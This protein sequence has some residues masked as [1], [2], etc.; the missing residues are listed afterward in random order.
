MLAVR[1]QLAIGLLLLTLFLIQSGVECK[2]KQRRN[3]DNTNTKAILLYHVTSTESI[4]IIDKSRR[5][6]FLDGHSSVLDL[7][8][9]EQSKL[10]NLYTLLYS[11][12]THVLVGTREKILNVTLDT[13]ALN[14]Q[15]N[16][17]IKKIKINI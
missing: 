4:K 9:P 1:K 10:P 2:Q 5:V 16:V 11:S 15:L 17:R 3:R 13:L 6:S 12:D 14:E 8:N 7:Q